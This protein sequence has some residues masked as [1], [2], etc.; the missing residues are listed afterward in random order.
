MS[1][2]KCPCCPNH[3]DIDNLNCGRGRDYFKTETNQTKNNHQKNK[4]ESTM[5]LEEKTFSK[6]RACGHFLHHSNNSVDL[7]FLS[8]E[9]KQELI[10]ILSKCLDNWK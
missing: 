1:K 9:E 8:D 4:D 3:C 6:I 7:N 5:T 2:E 10:K